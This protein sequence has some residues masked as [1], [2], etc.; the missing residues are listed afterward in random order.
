MFVSAYQEAVTHMRQNC[1]DTLVNLQ[2]VFKVTAAN[3][4]GR[5]AIARIITAKPHLCDV[6]CNVGGFGVFWVSGRCFWSDRK[7]K[8]WIC[9]RCVHWHFHT[10]G[11][12]SS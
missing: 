1:K 6:E 11:I 9:F 7:D 5:L 8:C 3:D 12:W 4:F 10:D 2:E